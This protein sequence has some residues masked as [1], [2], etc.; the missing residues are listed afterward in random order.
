MTYFDAAVCKRGHR[1]GKSDPKCSQC[2]A[3]VLAKCQECGAGIRGG[4]QVVTAWFG[5]HVMKKEGD[6]IRPAFCNACGSAFPWADR[7]AHVYRLQNLL[8]DVDL[9]EADRLTVREQLEALEQSDLSDEDQRKRWERIRKLAPGFLDSARE[10]VT[11][12]ATEAILKGAG[13]S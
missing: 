8:D 5:D 6:Y 9:P 3:D 11:K 4:T 12:I 13:I 1:V 7:K 2:G 10:V